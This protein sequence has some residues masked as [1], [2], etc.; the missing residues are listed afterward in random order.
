M[1]N[2]TDKPVDNAIN[3]SPN[4]SPRPSKIRI[5]LWTL[6]VALLL[7]PAIVMQFSNEVNWQL[8]DF[9]IAGVLMFAVGSAL[10]LLFKSSNNR[11]YRFAGALTIVT[12]FLL[13]W[14]NAAVGIVGHAN[15]D[16]N[17][18]YFAVLVT[19]LIGS[20]AVRFKAKGMRLVLLAC[21]VVHIV[22]TIIALVIESGATIASVDVSS[23]DASSNDVVINSYFSPLARSLLLNAVFVVLFLVAA[24]L[25]R[26]VVKIKSSE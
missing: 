15:N 26:R 20:I 2:N 22:V 13:I 4:D 11:R 16:A 12:L 1:L 6:A 17:L 25:F 5:I 7:T 19:A 3:N 8:S 24:G 23:N 9:V 10:E 14:I 21:A 18:L